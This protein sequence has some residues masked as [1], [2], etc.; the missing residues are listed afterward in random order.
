MI[1]LF[2]ILILYSLTSIASTSTYIPPKAFKYFSVINNELNRVF[3][4][5][6]LKHYIPSLI[7]HESCISLKHK[8]CWEPTSELLSAREQ[9]VGLGQ[10][11]RAYRLNG[12][13]RFD[14][15]KEIRTRHMQELRELSWE[16]I[17]QRPDLQ[18]RAMILMVK[19]NYNA[20]RT[21]TG[22]V[23]RL[24]MTDSAYNSGLGNVNKERIV[25]GLAKD[26]NPQY[27]DNNVERY[28]QKSKKPLYG[29]RSACD[30]NSHHVHDVFNNKMPKYKPYFQ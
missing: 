9:G 27:W 6:T 7:E 5:L 4:E 8:R 26:C 3:P 24:K 10:L 11:T 12:S 1:K 16:N 23:N 15:L 29:G 20:L 18:I 14:S 2:F 28:C 21:V 13:I 19:N 25:C 17:K 30:I 22:P